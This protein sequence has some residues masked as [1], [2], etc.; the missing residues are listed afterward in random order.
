MLILSHKVV[1]KIGNKIILETATIQKKEEGKTINPNNSRIVSAIGKRLR[2]MLSTIFQRDNA[3][4]GFLIQR[5][6]A[7][8]MNGKNQ[9]KICQSPR[10]QRENLFISD[11]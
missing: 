9:E 3:D 5:L 2:L 1:T 4:S 10:I 6:S 8:L 7:P 11:L